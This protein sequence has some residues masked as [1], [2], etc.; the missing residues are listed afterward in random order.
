MPTFTGSLQMARI[1]DEIAIVST[2]LAATPAVAGSAVV[3]ER[4]WIHIAIYEY[5][6][7]L[8]DTRL[9]Y[10]RFGPAE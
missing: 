2:M 9:R 8:R 10:L 1:E 6:G 4:G 5:G 3:D 7:G